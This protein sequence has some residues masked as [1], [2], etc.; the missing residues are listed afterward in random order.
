MQR[1]SNFI[2]LF[3]IALFIA[4]PTTAQ[5]DRL[6]SEY[7]LDDLRRLSHDAAQG[8]RTGTPGAEAARRFIVG[9]MKDVRAKSLNKGFLHPFTF[10]N[11][12]GEEVEGVNVIGY[13]RGQEETAFVITA[14][15]DHLGVRDSLIYNGADDNASGVAALL[16]MME[17]FKANRPRH[18]LVFAAL[19]GEEMGLQGAK[20]FLEDDRIPLE[21]I[22]L[23]I[24]MDMISMND[25]N[26]LYVAGT[27][28]YPNLKPII[29]KIDPQPLNL[30]IGHDSPDLGNDDWTLQSDHGAFHRK[31][32]PFLYFGVEDHAHYH[33]PTDVFENVNQE[34]Y[35]RAAHA[36]LD[37]ILALDT[38]LN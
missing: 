25:K 1:Y 11:R 15:Y 21:N 36:I 24:N 7:M 34:F 19:D 31:G 4:L 13:V 32:I 14:H 38:S 8:R 10:K 27:H 29:E 12:A 23:N 28:H 6:D 30:K 16:A 33:K 22:V 20:A 26:E 9:Q 2:A 3:I 35:V 37:C 18:T 17:Y 5:I